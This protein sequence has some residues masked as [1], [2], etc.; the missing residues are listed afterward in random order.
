MANQVVM[1]FT[2]DTA[3]ATTGFDKVGDASK[4]MSDQL[5]DASDGFGRAGDA[6]DGA[7]GKARGLADTLGGATNITIGLAAAAKGDLVG[8]LE[9][10]ASG[11]ADLAGGFASFLI[12]MLEKTRLGTLAKAAADRVAAAGAKAWAAAQWV[13][14]SALFASPV[15]WIVV[16]IV[17]LVAIVVLLVRHTRV[18]GDA[19]RAVWQTVRSW[20]SSTWEWLKTLP[21]RLR[22]VFGAVAEWVARPFRD[23]FGAIRTA[24]TKAW[25]AL[26]GGISRAWE[27]LQTLPDKLRG[28][29]GKI[30]QIIVGP[31]AAGFNAI[32][33]AWNAGPGAWSFKFPDWAPGVGGKSFDVP[34][35][36]VVSMHSGGRVPGMPGQVVPVLAMAGERVSTPGGAGGTVRLG[37]DGTRLG[38]ALI[39]VIALAIK[40][41]G[42]DPAVLNL[43]VGT[44]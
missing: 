3:G 16:A 15:T 34:N 26:Q 42:G 13:M 23:G 6:A 9:Q 27:W 41:H 7:E 28:S 10:A 37:S 29:F 2:T 17:A 38:D 35:M 14:N 12:P 36:P 21:E 33:K 44:V 25:G 5:D 32:A 43:R 11:V 39:E 22:D 4:K 24:W 40:A 19:W 1:T 30:T 31:F 8:G 20:A 18:F